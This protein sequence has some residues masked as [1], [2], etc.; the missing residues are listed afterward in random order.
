MV[1]TLKRVRWRE[2]EIWRKLTPQK[3]RI[4]Q[5]FFLNVTRFS[6]WQNAGGGLKGM[7]TRMGGNMNEAM[8]AA[9]AKREEV[10]KKR[11]EKEAKKK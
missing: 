7:E 8:A 2:P 1:E 9:A 11:E 5:H 4:F 10:K 6:L 3:Y